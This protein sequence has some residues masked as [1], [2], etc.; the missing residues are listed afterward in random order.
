M[1]ANIKSHLSSIRI[2]NK[3]FAQAKG[4]RL[5]LLMIAVVGVMAALLLGAGTYEIFA[6][7]T[8]VKL[9]VDSD[10]GVDD[11]A[12]IA[13]LLSQDRYPVDVVGLASVAG[14]TT[15]ENAANNILTILDATGHQDIPVVKGAAEPL[16]QAPSRTGPLIHGPD[17]LWFVGLQNPHDLSQLPNDAAAFYCDNA[18]PDVTIVA[19]GPLTNLAQAVAACP[20]EMQQYQQIVILGGAKNGGNRTPVAEFNVWIDPEAAAQVLD[21]GLNPILLPLDTFETFSISEDDIAELATDGT[22]V[23]QL[24]AGPLTLYAGYQ[25]GLGGASAI[26]VPDVTAIMYA[27]RPNLGS[28]VSGLVKVVPGIEED[29]PTRQYRG[30]TVIGLDL[31]DRIPMIVD[32]EELGQL[33]DAAFSDPNFDLEAALGAILASEPDN[34]QVL[35]DINERVMHRLFMRYLTQ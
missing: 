16:L 4:R 14:N 33:A 24:L 17:G 8:P 2:K 27:L 1:Y 22:P 28:G 31:A 12:A 26:A 9:I 21:A 30:Q 32:D 20:A 3:L 34:A 7:R 29:D 23:G 18:Q 15:M 13:W 35:T 19:L 6:H 10:M 11:A 5:I 25:T